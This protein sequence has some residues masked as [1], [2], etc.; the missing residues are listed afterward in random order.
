MTRKIDKESK[1]AFRE[2]FKAI[3]SDE[4]EEDEKVDFYTAQK[5]ANVSLINILNALYELYPLLN[6]NYILCFIG[7]FIILFRL[8][9]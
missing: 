9:L 2:I 7:R 3:F 1:G 5:D 4:R 8:L 6:I